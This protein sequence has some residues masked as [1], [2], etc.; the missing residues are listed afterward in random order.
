MNA[1]FSVVEGL[2]IPLPLEN[3]DTDTII[4]VEHLLD[5]QRET[6]RRHAFEMLKYDADGAP[7][8]GCALNDTD[9]DGAP[10]LVAGRNFGCGSSREPAVWAVQALGIRAVLA[11]SFGDIFASNCGQN[12]VLAARLPA[13]SIDA[14]MHE[15]RARRPLRVD[16]GARQVVT[17]DGRA[18]HFDIDA[19]QRE[20]LLA[21]G[22]E[23]DLLLRELPDIAAWQAADRA[24]RPWAWSL[25]ASPLTTD[26]TRNPT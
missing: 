6:L 2:A 24:R 23:L 22:E 13:A 26:S 20:R 16:L 10:I 11:E 25:P 15:A 14:L 19:W 9:L 8:P 1:P 18:L 7:A 12:G 3:V 17:V 21:G 5:V 4:R